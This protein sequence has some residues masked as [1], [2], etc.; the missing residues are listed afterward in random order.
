M[1]EA[2]DVWKNGRQIRR[3]DAEPR[4]ERRGKLVDRSRRN[5]A[6]LAG[7]V[8]TVNG[9]SRKRTEQTPALD[10][11]AENELVTPPPVIGPGTVC[12]IGAAE[13]GRGKRG[14]LR[15]DVKLD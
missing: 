3:A 10:C 11:A 13:I 2:A 4:R 5:P 14:D 9:E 12:R 15:R 1:G 8:G 7:I 6:A